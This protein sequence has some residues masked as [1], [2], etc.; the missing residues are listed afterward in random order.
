MSTRTETA[1][2]WKEFEALV[3]SGQVRGY[4]IIHISTLMLRLLMKEP[5]HAQVGQIGISNIYD[6]QLLDWMFTT[7]RIKP[8]VV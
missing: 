8:S 5:R 4:R 3:A 7:S 1:I 2:V 6:P